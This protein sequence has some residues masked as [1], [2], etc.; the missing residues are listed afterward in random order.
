M[1]KF[2]GLILVGIMFFSSTN[3]V[4]ADV[5]AKEK[6]IEKLNSSDLFTSGEQKMSAKANDDDGT[7]EIYSNEEKL[8]SFTINEEYIELE[9]Y[10]VK[11]TDDDA[12]EK[13]P[14]EVIR[15]FTVGEVI[16]AIFELSGVSKEEIK[17]IDEHNFSDTY[18]KYGLQLELSNYE[19]GEKPEPDDED[20]AYISIDLVK[21]FKMSLDTEVIS[22]LIEKYSADYKTI[23][24]PKVE[25]PGI[26]N[27]STGIDSPFALITL[28]V[29][30]SST[31]LILLK[32]KAY[33]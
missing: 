29:V 7:I 14:A 22:T 10:D 32:K 5:I 12:E 16:N 26:E 4:S 30:A 1:K 13:L 23:I 18:E 20:Y 27:P 8:F 25:N 11:I 24:P 2:I 28:L 6:I 17:T 9:N 33:L 15:Y 19:Y 3:I 31:V 21:H